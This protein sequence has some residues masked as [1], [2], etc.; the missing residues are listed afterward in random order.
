MGVSRDSRHALISLNVVLM[1]L[2][3]SRFMYMLLE[4]I[5][6]ITALHKF[7]PGQVRCR[8]VH[9]E[10]SSLTESLLPAF[11]TGLVF[12]SICG[13]ALIGQLT[14]PLQDLVYARKSPTKGP[15]ARLYGACIAAVVFPVGCF[16]CALK[17]S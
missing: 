4:S 6:L 11:Q 14:N 13:G 10:V 2:P 12:L 16:I 8:G 7:S 15:E 5:G 1:K 3:P 9:T 17:K